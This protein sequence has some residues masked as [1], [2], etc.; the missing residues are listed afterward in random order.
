[1]TQSE[2]IL[3]TRLGIIHACPMQSEQQIASIRT[4]S[5]LKQI[6]K[7]KV[8]VQGK[9]GEWERAG[10]GGGK[11]EAEINRLVWFWGNEEEEV[12]SMS[13]TGNKEMESGGCAPE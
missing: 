10:H 11:S 5:A 8:G 2:R 13:C 7:K 1:M 4:H 6:M 3:E 9:K 12:S